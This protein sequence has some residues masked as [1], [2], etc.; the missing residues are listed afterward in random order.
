MPEQIKQPFT[1]DLTFADRL[2]GKGLQIYGKSVD[3]EKLPLNKRIFL[4]SVVDLRKDPITAQSMTADERKAL[5]DVI[6]NK[7]KPIAADLD[8][9]AK[10][11]TKNLAK[12]NKAKAEKNKDQMMYPEF[13]EQY[14][15]DL[16]AIKQFKRGVI[17]PE[18]IKLTSGEE[19]SYAQDF[20]HRQ[21]NV[22][23][24]NV[25]PVIGYEDYGVP[26]EQAR[27]IHS[28]DLPSALHTT[29]GQF[30]YRED[31]KNRA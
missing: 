23:Y 18:F 19:L 8:A 21:A 16:D 14:K 22:P 15:K 11:L 9:Y 10:Y 26:A 5:A 31:P 7:Y 12:H 1:P 20:A 3:R 28:E 17:T 29:F 13:V 30:T 24:F 25:K 27:S 2:V 4:E 6:L